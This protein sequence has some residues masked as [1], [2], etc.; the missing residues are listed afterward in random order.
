MLTAPTFA[1]EEKIVHPDLAPYEATRTPLGTRDSLRKKRKNNMN[2]ALR[3]ANSESILR[4]AW[5]TRPPAIKNTIHP[6][7]SKRGMSTFP[8]KNK[9][10]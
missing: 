8:V 4:T 5:G 7:R 2:D 10:K 9:N 6:D 1:R 3:Y